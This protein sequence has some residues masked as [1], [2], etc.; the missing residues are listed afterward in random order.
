MRSF[1][2]RAAWASQAWFKAVHA[3]ILRKGHELK[4]V[5]VRREDLPSMGRLLGLLRAESKT[6]FVLF[7][8]DLSF[9]HDD[10]HYKSL[11][12]VLDGGIEGRPGQHTILRHLESAPSDAARYDRE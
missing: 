1:G 2:E 10:Q 3:E 11:K 4:M 12:A 7:C 6:R 5:E 9:S 8:D